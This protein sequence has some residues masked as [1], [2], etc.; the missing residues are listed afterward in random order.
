MVS[1]QIECVRATEH[2]SSVSPH[3]FPFVHRMKCICFLDIQVE[4]HKLVSYISAYYCYPNVSFCTSQAALFAVPE[5]FISILLLLP[6]LECPC[7]LPF[8][9]LYT[10]YL[11]F[12]MASLNIVVFERLLNVYDLA[13]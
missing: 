12:K 8:P 1:P 9:S 3:S 4:T 5:Y 13:L 11:T 7:H 6:H 10:Y 2:R